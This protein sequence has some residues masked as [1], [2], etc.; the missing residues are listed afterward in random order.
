MAPKNGKIILTRQALGGQAL[1][2]EGRDVMRGS[3]RGNRLRLFLH[4]AAGAARRL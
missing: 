3:M 4:P 1:G 2:V